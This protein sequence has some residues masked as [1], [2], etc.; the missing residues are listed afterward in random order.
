MHSARRSPVQRLSWRWPILS[1]LYLAYIVCILTDL[2]CA[3]CFIRNF[4]CSVEGEVKHT[5]HVFST[6][7]PTW[8]RLEPL[9][10]RI[11]ESRTAILCPEID[12]ISAHSLQYSGVGGRSVGGFWW[13]LHFSWRPMP[14]QEDRRRK[15][16][17]DPIRCDWQTTFSHFVLLFNSNLALAGPKNFFSLFAL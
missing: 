4:A 12:V 15:A 8:H 3:S 6:S 14:K 1:A 17:T 7:S 13:S 10:A 5:P 11:K 16:P 9:L 2:I